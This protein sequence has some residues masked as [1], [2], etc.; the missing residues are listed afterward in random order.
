VIFFSKSK[1]FTY[2]KRKNNKTYTK[3]LD[4]AFYTLQI[5]VNL[6]QHYIGQIIGSYV[7]QIGLT[8]TIIAQSIKVITYFIFCRL[9]SVRSF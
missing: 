1:P 4:Q 6:M 5:I 3:S 8:N 9:R 2:F 7:E